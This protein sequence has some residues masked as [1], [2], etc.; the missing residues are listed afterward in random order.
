[1]PKLKDAGEVVVVDYDASWPRQ[2]EE[3][4]SRIVATLG[5]V[6]A[7]VVAIEHVGSTAVPGLAAKPI[8][9]IIPGV[10]DL[11]IGELC[12]EPLERLGYEYLG[13]VG[14]PGRF[15]FRKGDPRTHHLHLVQHGSEFWERHIRFRDL[16]RADPEV[17]RQ[18][19]ALKRELAVKYRTDRLAYTE[20]KTPFIESALARARAR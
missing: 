19:D 1:M 14:I 7:G 11:S 20:A 5:D 18:Y 13:E 16:L 12:I 9:D 15:Y 8:I 17:A 6:M 3:E 10:R 4:K 2:F